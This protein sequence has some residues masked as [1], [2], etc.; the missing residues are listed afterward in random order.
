M[1]MQ[2]HEYEQFVR[3]L[4]GAHENEPAA[5]A[6][7]LAGEAGEVCDLLKKHWGH[8]HPLDK[9][10]LGKELGDV[11]WYVAAVGAQFGISLNDIARA[12]VAKLTQRYPDGFSPEAS[13][14]RADVRDAALDMDRG[15]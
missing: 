14:A 13:L 9:A 12:N 5:H 4:M 10:K 2:M 3:N 11:L 6:L 7:G 8:R 1:T 15:G